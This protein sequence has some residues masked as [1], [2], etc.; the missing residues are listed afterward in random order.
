[1]NF[2]GFTL[3]III[4]CFYDIVVKVSSLATWKE[5]DRKQLTEENM[6][7]EFGELIGLGNTKGLAL[8]HTVTLLLVEVFS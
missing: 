6:W 7:T 4:V 8:Q 1:L 5:N 3:E 2:V